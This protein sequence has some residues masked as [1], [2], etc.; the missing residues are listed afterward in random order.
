M[1]AKK[2]FSC[3]RTTKSLAV[4]AFLYRGLS[5]MDESVGQQLMNPVEREI[6][7]GI[8]SHRWI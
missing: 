8:T 1:F 7:S 6:T 3:D 2:D 5:K 4:C